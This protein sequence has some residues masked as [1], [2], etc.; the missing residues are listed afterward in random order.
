MNLLY[1]IHLQAFNVGSIVLYDSR[2]AFGQVLYSCQN[3]CRENQNDGIIRLVT[4]A[5]RAEILKSSG[6]LKNKCFRG[7]RLVLGTE[8]SAK[9]KIQTIGS[10]AVPVLGYTFGII[11]WLQ[12]ELE[13]IDRKTRKMLYFHGQHHTKVDI[14]R[15]HIPRK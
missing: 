3:A 4:Q 8:L 14:D 10:W 13:G 5:Q 2:P 1:K 11:N 12:E 9:N 6:K 15:L 7:L